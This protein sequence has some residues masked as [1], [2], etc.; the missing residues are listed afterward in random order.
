[1]GQRP[2]SGLNRARW[3]AEVAEALH[4]ARLLLAQLEASGAATA[5]TAGLATHVQ[6]AL[7]EVDSLRRGGNSPFRAGF[8]PEPMKFFP[9][10]PDRRRS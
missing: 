8:N 4:R 6:D 1:M 9:N 2:F 10:R 7:A 3:L 5:A